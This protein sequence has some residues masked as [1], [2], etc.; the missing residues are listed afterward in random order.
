MLC[1][2]NNKIKKKKKKKNND[3]DNDNNNNNNNNNDDDDDDDD[4]HNRNHNHNHN[5]NRK[6]NKHNSNNNNKK[7]Q[8]EQQQPLAKWLVMGIQTCFMN[9]YSN[10][11]IYTHHASRI[12][13]V[14]P[15]KIHV[16]VFQVPNDTSLPKRMWP[17]ILTR[18]WPMMD[19]HWMPVQVQPVELVKMKKR[20]IQNQAATIQWKSIT[21]L[22]DDVPPKTSD[23][24]YLFS[25][26][27]EPKRKVQTNH[28]HVLMIL[29]D[30]GWYQFEK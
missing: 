3:N 22:I 14:S 1:A 16:V 20:V 25:Y 19:M 30:N 29:R 10:R 6:H 2:N 26:H 28:K 8:E 9:K 7:K 15:L 5:H 21:Y 4:I 13:K 24:P 23:A 18:G 11:I 27:K 17:L 12:T